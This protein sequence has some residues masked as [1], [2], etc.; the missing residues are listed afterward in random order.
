MNVMEKNPMKRFLPHT[1]LAVVALNSALAL[2]QIQTRGIPS[3]LP[4]VKLDALISELLNKNPELQALRK[5]YEAALT[6]PAQESALP[7]PRI[8]AGW[9]SN[10]NPIPG[11]GLGVEPTSNIGFQIAQELPYPGK[12]TIRGSIAR[13]EADSEAQMY[14]AKEL[15]LTGQLKTA[16][17]EL[18]FLFETEDILRRNRTLLQQLLKVAE[19]RYAVGKAMQQDLFKS[20]VEISILENKLVLIGQKKSTLAAEINVLLNRLPNETLGEPEQTGTLPELGSLPSLQSQAEMASPLLRAQQS[21]IDGKQL[22]VQLARKD[23]YPDFDLMGGY[24]SMGQMKDMW[25]FKVQVNVPIYFWR[26]Q[27][28][29]LEE[30]SLRLVEAQKTY[31]ATDQTLSF[32]IRDRYLAAEASRK[33]VDLYWKRIL[34]QAQF[35]LESSLASYETGG[36][37]FLTVLSNIS[38]ILENEINYSEQRAEYLKALAGLEELVARPQDRVFASNGLN[39]NEVQ[40]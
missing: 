39:K 9:V 8:T 34:P 30:S 13:K 36:V 31:R 21:V 27:R 6:R 7:D 19:A 11:A 4:T 33:L 29:A 16:F 23:Y 26:K 22:G 2:A 3:G 20:Q 5:R 40:Q 25:E 12:R 18:R 28:Y 17:Y 32:R 15:N 14:R 10:G 24:Y 1:V 35:A 37:D 38:S